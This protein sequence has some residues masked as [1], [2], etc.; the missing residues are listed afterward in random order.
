VAVTEFT[1]EFIWTK[2]V[3]DGEWHTIPSLVKNHVDYVLLSTN[4][5]N[6]GYGLG[7]PQFLHYLQKHAKVV[8]QANGPAEGSLIL[9]DVRAFTGA[10]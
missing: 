9:Y 2:R 6:Q 3:V 8:F 4:L 10:Q 7:K 5:V 1:A